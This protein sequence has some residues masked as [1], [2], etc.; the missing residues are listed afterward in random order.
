MASSLRLTRCSQV[1]LLSYSRPFWAVPSMTRRPESLPTRWVMFMSSASERLS[2]GEVIGYASGSICSQ[3]GHCQTVLPS[4]V[5][6]T[7]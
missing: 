5:L 3:A 7:K 4:L 1:P 2:L 6:S